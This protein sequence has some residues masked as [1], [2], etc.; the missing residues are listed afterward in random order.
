M[1]QYTDSLRGYALR[2]HRRDGWKCVYC[3]LD[4]RE[5]FSSW[6]SLSEE[7][8]LPKGHPLRDDPRFIVTACAFCNVA[9]NQYFSKA[10]GRGIGLEDK[11]PEELIALRKPYVTE[12]RDSYRTF[13]ER[14]VRGEKGMRS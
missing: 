7:H 12:T 2:T 9:D 8:L 6:L 11:T 5:S 4:G 3:G 10:Q 1:P 13:W 14:H